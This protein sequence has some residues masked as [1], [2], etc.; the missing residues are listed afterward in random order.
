MPAR[1]LSSAAGVKGPNHSS[2]RI[3]LGVPSAIGMRSSAIP[4]TTAFQGSYKWSL[5][6]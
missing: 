4:K 1:S 5:F 6:G 3:L 2:G